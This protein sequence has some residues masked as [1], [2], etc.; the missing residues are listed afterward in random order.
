MHGS[1]FLTKS[2][3]HTLKKKKQ[4]LYQTVLVKLDIS[5]WKK[6][7]R[8]IFTILYKLKSN[9]LNDLNIKPNTPNLIQQKVEAAL[10]TLAQGKTLNRITNIAGTKINCGDS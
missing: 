9:W 6:G 2:Q 4:H 1:L 5:M 7:N 8:S 3:K 10:S